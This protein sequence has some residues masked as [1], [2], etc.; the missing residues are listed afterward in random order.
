MEGNSENYWRRAARNRFSR[1]TLVRGTALMSLGAASGSLLA[2]K[3]SGSSGSSS[4]S[5]GAKPAASAQGGNGQGVNGLIGRTG[6]K[7]TES[8]IM[9]GTYVDVVGSN[10][11]TLDPHGSS[12][13]LTMQAVSPVMSRLL[14][15]KS[16]WEPAAKY[17]RNT[18]PDLALSAESPDATT[19]TFKLRPDAKFHNTAPANGH[20]VEAEDI[21]VTYTRATSPTNANRGSLGMIDPA[22]IT[23]PDKNTVVF[24]LKY[25]YAPFSKLMASGVYGWIFPR[26]VGSGGYDPTKQI[27]GSGP[28]TMVSYT[29]D[30]SY[31]YKKN[32]DWFE[33]GRPY[34]DGVK[35]A[36]VPDFNQQI[37]QLTAGNLDV[38]YN[39]TEENLDQAKKQNPTA[40]TYTDWG[41]GDGQM[42]FPLGSDTNS[43]FKD[44][45]L[46]R[47]ISLAFDRSAMA[48]VAF[49]DR[50]EPDF[51]TPQSFGKW[52]LHMEQ[53]PSDT[54]Q[55]YKFNL[56]QA[57]QLVE[58]A[59]GS[60][61][62]IKLLSPTPFPPSGEPTWFHAEREMVFNF[63]KALPWQITLSTIDYNKDWVGGGKGVRY[64]TFPS[65]NDSMVWA[66]LEGRQDV[67]EY[68]FGWYGSQS[69]TNL[70]HLKDDKLDGMIAQAR[71]IV[72]E[73]ERAKAYVDLQKY[74][75]DQMF[76]VAGNPN[77]L[78]YYMI[79]PRVR[80][81]TYGD[82]YGNGTQTWSQ[83]WLQK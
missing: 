4:A 66:G 45:R 23:T 28:F 17:D 51:Y 27:I 52:S 30:V 5:S 71:T 68:I 65:P 70:S 19:W 55:W 59:G 12:S 31:N 34:I 15:Y 63:L 46:R 6:T 79:R 78:T 2:C 1:R 83:L 38:V 26:E 8:P 14:R 35:R 82:N 64:G 58:A 16:V 53:L 62:N 60:S 33:K 72:N 9:G 39:L 40:E 81:W 29:P 36:I 11:P 74:M 37:A 41:P 43:A 44:I 77:G 50:A 76:S 32:P 49:N 69:S 13:V 47:A 56:Q 3:S 18:E 75:A 24:K 67:D 73:D 25:P 42:Y 20:A 22:Q 21:K 57:K 48:H 10:A 80:N 7:P 54:A 61:L